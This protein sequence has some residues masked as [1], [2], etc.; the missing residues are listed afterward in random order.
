MHAHASLDSTDPVGFLSAVQCRLRRVRWFLLL[1]AL[2]LYGILLI[3]AEFI[4]VRFMVALDDR[5]VYWGV[6]ALIGVGFT[7]WITHWEDHWTA[8]LAA[9]EARH[10]AAAQAVMQLEAA[11][12]TARTVAHTINQPLAVIRGVVELYRDT[13]PDERDDTDLQTI[14][15]HVDRAADLVR[16]FQEIS[17]YHTVPYAG[18]VPMLD[19]SPPPPST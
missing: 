7:L 11:Q 16:Q 13:P 2:I 5:L 18:G 14:L 4:L 10:A 1:G 19:L 8:E 9:L 3:A 17:R 6:A 12:A 15:R